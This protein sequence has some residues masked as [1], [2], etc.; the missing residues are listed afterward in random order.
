MAKGRDSE[1]IGGALTQG[2]RLWPCCVRESTVGRTGGVGRVGDV[3]AFKSL[4]G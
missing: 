2:V 3:W 1:D 4:A